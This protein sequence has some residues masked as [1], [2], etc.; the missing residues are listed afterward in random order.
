M[1]N[2]CKPKQKPIVVIRAASGAELSSYEKRK[3][4]NIEENAQENKIETIT[5]NVDGNKQQL[6]PL[7]KEVE[8][9]L[10]SLALKSSIVP[11]DISSDE[12]FFIKCMLDESLLNSQQD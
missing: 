12:L 10:G 2:V 8:I 9:N 1:F 11:A 5:L 6:A 4:K 3:L 7:N